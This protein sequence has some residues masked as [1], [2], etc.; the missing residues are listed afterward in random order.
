MA[1]EHEP[2]PM[3]VHCPT[4]D[5]VDIAVPMGSTTFYEESEGPPERYTLLRCPQMHPL[6]VVQNRF[7]GV[8][9]NEDGPYRVYPPQERQLSVEVPQA[10][11]DAHAEARLSF[12]AK[13]Y[14]AT[15]VMC[16]RTLEGVCQLQ[17]VKEDT[18]AKSI[19]TMKRLGLI[20]GRL[21]EWA[22]LLKD[23]RNASAHFNTEIVG[24]QD[25]E[26]C[27]AFNE[28][29]LDYLYVLKQRFDAM[30]DRRELL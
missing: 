18:L 28:A 15:V 24:R 12:S 23:V 13:A 5:V 3:A 4:C 14:K 19:S 10:L 27:L 1:D 21:W 17:G 16:G 20:D 6:L 9:F 11:R 26:D 30:K 8:E 2:R 29:L 22:K 25:A 7:V